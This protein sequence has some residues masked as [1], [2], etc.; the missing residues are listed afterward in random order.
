MSSS[1]QI[2]ISE[3]FIDMR[4]SDFIDV[5]RSIKPTILQSI[6]I[7][8][9]IDDFDLMRVHIEN[10]LSSAVGIKVLKDIVKKS[11]HSYLNLTHNKF[12]TII[13]ELD[14]KATDELIEYINSSGYSKCILGAMFANCIQDRS[15]FHFNQTGSKLRTHAD[16]YKIGLVYNVELYVDPYLAYQDH[17]IILLNEVKTNTELINSSFKNEASFTPRVLIEYNIG[18]LCNDSLVCDVLTHKYSTN[19]YKYISDIRDKK[20]DDLLND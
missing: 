3:I 1:I 10:E 14:V 12:D 8:N 5:D 13:N 15:S 11:K 7:S 19:Y 2:G 6:A 17:T 4:L 18:Y 20:I 9:T 16:I